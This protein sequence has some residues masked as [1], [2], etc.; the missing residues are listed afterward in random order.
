MY[1]AEAAFDLGERAVDR[2]GVGD[3]GL[4]GDDLSA[5]GLRGADGFARARFVGSIAEA[6]GMT[7]LRERNDGG[8]ADAARRTGNERDSRFNAV[9]S[10]DAPAHQRTGPGHSRAETGEQDEVAV[11]HAA[12]VDGFEQRERNRSG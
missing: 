4:D 1:R 8:P 5:D 12:I 7:R 11:T 10:S 3:V 6:D 9:R 2:V